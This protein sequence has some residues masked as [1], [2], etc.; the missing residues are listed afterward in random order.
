ML[1]KTAG[2]CVHAYHSA[3]TWKGK[4]CKISGTA[5]KSVSSEFGGKAF[6]IPLKEFAIS[7]EP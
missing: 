7:Y 2:S 4:E 3:S 6:Q 5:G 1:A